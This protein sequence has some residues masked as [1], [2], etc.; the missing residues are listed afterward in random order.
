DQIKRTYRRL[1][2]KF[3]PDHCKGKNP[4]EAAA[5]FN[6]VQQAYS[7]LSDPEKRKLYDQFG[8]SGLEAGGPSVAQRVWRT[9]PA[10]FNVRDFADSAGGFESV[11]EQFFRRG[12]RPRRAPSPQPARGQDVVKKISLPFL[13]AALGTSSVVKLR[14]QGRTGPA[15]MQTLEVKIPPGVDDGSRIRIRGKGRAS[16]TGGPR[17]DLYLQVAV[18][19]HPYFWRRGRDIYLELPITFA[20]AALGTTVDVPTLEGTTTLKVPPGV[21][22][23]QKL[24]LREKGIPPATPSGRPGHQYVLIKIVTPPKLTPKAR[25]ALKDFQ[26]ACDYKP[27]RFK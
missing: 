17:G 21:S 8:H 18:E 22:S 4:A 15:K 24:R 3:H 10:D 13:K 27:D 5:K 20:E 9:G 23:G 14:I 7:V 26:Q 2:K 25:Q 6:E 11:F 16:P 1:A 12:R 19:P